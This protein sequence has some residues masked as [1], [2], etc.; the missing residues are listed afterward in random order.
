MKEQQTKLLHVQRNFVVDQCCHHQVSAEAK[1]G[2]H[3]M[4]WAKTQLNRKLSHKLNF[5]A[6]SFLPTSFLKNYNIDKIRFP[7]YTL[8]MLFDI[9][10]IRHFSSFI[11]HFVQFSKRII[12][13]S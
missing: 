2:A 1:F 7:V 9:H 11:D 6:N 4:K 13:T 12:Q 8:K 3:T 10:F 5:Q